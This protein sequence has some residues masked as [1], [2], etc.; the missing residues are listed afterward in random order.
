MNTVR[1]GRLQLVTI[2]A[3]LVFG[4]AIGYSSGAMTRA[5]GHDS[6]IAMLMA[7]A[8][9]AMIMV[10]TVWLAGR[11]GTTG[12]GTYLPRLA[13]RWAGALLLALLCLFYAGSFVTSAITVEQHVSDYL[14]MET[15]LIVFVAV[16]ALVC[17]YGV[18]HGVEGI[19]RLSVLGLCLVFLLD[20]LMVI[21]SLDHFD[22][23]RLQP[24]LDHGVGPVALASIAAD[25]DVAMA[26]ASALVLLPLTGKPQRWLRLGWWGLGLGALVTSVWTVFEVGVLGPHVTAQY[27]IACM[28]MARAAQLSIWLHRYEMVMVVLF[29]YSCLAQSMILLYCTVETAGALFGGRVSR[30]I[31]V[32]VFSLFTIPVQHLLGADREGYRLFLE[33]WWPALAVPVAFGLPL[34]AGALALLRPGVKATGSSA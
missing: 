19:A 5:V 21:G 1:I 31:L 34:A 12:P 2:F 33:S 14:L 18:A 22:L 20:I 3:N 4:K 24:L 11:F 30:G 29:V 10:P 8:T 13:G 25:T 28:Q 26:T 27:L 6:W 15:P 17:W 7:F 23:L 32:A 16:Y 9:G